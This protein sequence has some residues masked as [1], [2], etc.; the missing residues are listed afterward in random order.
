MSDDT[1]PV[2]NAVDALRAAGIVVV[3]I[4]EELDRWQIG[5]LLFSDAELVRIA[6]SRGLMEG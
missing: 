5:D 2:L 1:D 6:M 4:G 3:P